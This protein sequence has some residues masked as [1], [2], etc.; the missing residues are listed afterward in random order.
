MQGGTTFHF[1]TGGIKEAL[2]R[3]GDGERLF[4]GV[5]PLHLKP[6]RVR[7]ASLVTHITYA[8]AAGGSP[9]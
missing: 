4:D 9:A 6:V 7:A 8:R 5:P 2:A 1:V 3:A